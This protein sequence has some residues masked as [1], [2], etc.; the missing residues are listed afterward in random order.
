[1]LAVERPEPLPD[2]C[3][4]LLVTCE[5]DLEFLSTVKPN[6][7]QIYG[8][9][10]GLCARASETGFFLRNLMTRRVC[11]DCA[12]PMQTPEGKPGEAEDGNTLSRKKLLSF[13]TKNGPMP[14]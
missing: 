11:N 2:C 12:K 13:L 9:P 14:R 4:L 7:P 1:M 10:P 6:N 5:R 3:A 8:V